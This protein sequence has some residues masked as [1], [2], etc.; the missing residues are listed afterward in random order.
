M[1]NE[2]DNSVPPSAEVIQR[3]FSHVN[4]DG[5]APVHQPKLGPCWI[6]TAG[7]S[8]GYGQFSRSHKVKVPAHRVSW[9]I[10]NGP[11]PDGLF[12]LHRCDRPECVRPDHLFLGT[13]DDNMADM[14][15]KGRQ[16]AG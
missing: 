5:P 13:G 8:R 2:S 1:N 14:V 9:V 7:T 6:W 11:I 12:V 16:A 10:H 4:K 15:S 3:F